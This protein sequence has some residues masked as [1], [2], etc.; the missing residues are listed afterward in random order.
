MKYFRCF[1]FFFTLVVFT[2]LACIILAPLWIFGLAWTP[3]GYIGKFWANLLL[4]SAGVKVRTF[5]MENIHPYKKYIFISNHQSHFDTLV[6]LAKLPPSY[7]FLA[8]RE[9]FRIPFFGWAL[10]FAGHIPVDRAKKGDFHKIL[11]QTGAVLR[12]GISVHFFAEATRSPDGKIYPFKPGAIL[13]AQET[14]I[15]IIPVGVVGTRDILPKGAW[16]PRPTQAALSVGKPFMVSDDSS[17]LLEILE[18]TRKTVAALSGQEPGESHP[19]KTL[20]KSA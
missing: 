4:F 2:T 10:Y 3:G 17:R 14:H 5:G 1:L 7:R 20:R 6:L 12:K 13:L 9:L 19:K 8:K 15:P 11:D 18:S 16:L